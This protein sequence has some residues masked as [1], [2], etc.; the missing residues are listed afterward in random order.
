MFP[1]CWNVYHKAAS[2]FLIIRTFDLV[3]S[4]RRNAF[5]DF[6]D[7]VGSEVSMLRHLVIAEDLHPRGR[8]FGDIIG[9]RSSKD[10]MNSSTALTWFNPHGGRIWR[11]KC[12]CICNPPRLPPW[13]SILQRSTRLF[14][15]FP[16]IA[17]SFGNICAWSKRSMSIA[18]DLVVL[19][20]C[21]TREPLGS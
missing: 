5:S 16:V 21:T 7:A 19:L 2:S 20:S 1:P 12:H 3:W 13:A 8:H 15:Y 18:I 4:V 14:N 17:S 10:A 9:I 11:S 6:L